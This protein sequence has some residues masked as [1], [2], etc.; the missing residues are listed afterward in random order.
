MIRGSTWRQSVSIALG[1]AVLAFGR[2]LGRQCQSRLLGRLARFEAR[3]QGSVLA[4]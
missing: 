1:L 4:D 2:P 3:G